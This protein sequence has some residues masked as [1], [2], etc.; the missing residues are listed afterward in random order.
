M[1]VDIMRHHCEWKEA[2]APSLS[3]PR[4]AAAQ[5]PASAA[6]LL[7]EAAAVHGP[8]LRAGRGAG[9]GRR[10]DAVL[11]LLRQDLAD[12]VAA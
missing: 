8:P 3:A 12:E 5:A 4:V 7:A 9:R 6:E 11:G 1:D 10:L 2:P